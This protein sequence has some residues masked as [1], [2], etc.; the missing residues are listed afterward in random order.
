MPTSTTTR[1][2]APSTNPVWF[3]A[4]PIVAVVAR[5][6]WTPFD[7]E[8]PAA[9][10]AEVGRHPQRSGAGTLLMI[11]SALLLIPAAFALAAVLR[12]SKPRLARITT[13]MITTGA[14]GMAAFSMVGMF[15][16]YVAREP[17]RT[18][19]LDVWD[20]LVTDPKG[21]YTRLARR[22]GC[23][24]TYIG[25]GMSTRLNPLDAPPA[26]PAVRPHTM[27]GGHQA[28]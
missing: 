2:D 21:E 18:A 12:D 26:A 8:D 19:M 13:A 3:V 10:I 17:D 24:P 25:P 9:Y 23:E 28:G 16:S 5:T 14:V 11:L 15:A 4:A 6:M 27:T 7:D 1:N 22:L 20:R